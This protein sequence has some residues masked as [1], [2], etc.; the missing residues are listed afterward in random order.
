MSVFGCRICQPSYFI[1][2]IIM[3]RVMANFR[4]LRQSNLIFNLRISIVQ[5]GALIMAERAKGATQINGVVPVIPIPF[6]ED[7]SIDEASLRR[8]VEFVGNRQMAAMCLP[9]YASEFYK[10]SEAER[11]QVIGIAIDTNQRRIP[12]I[13]QANHG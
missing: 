9:A 4:V 11:E 1:I 12:V 10:L 8:C 7:D 6:H 2:G 3:S 5:E 13:A